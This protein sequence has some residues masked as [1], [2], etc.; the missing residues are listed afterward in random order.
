MKALRR[1]VVRPQLPQALAPLGPLVRNLRWSWHTPTKDLFADIDRS[2][3]QASGGD[4]VKLLG[5]ISIDR[6]DELA[7]DEDFLARMRALEADLETYLTA[8]RWYQRQL[9]DSRELPNLIAYFSMEYGI[10]ESLPNYSGGLGILAGDHL[11]SASDLGAPL[12]GVGLLYQFGYFWQSLSVDGWQQE[13]YQTHDPQGLPIDLVRRPDGSELRVTLPFPGNQSLSA[14]IWRAD[15][16]R[17]PLLLLD[18]VIDGNPEGLRAIT[19][20]LYG[21]NEDH[22]IKQEILLGVGG[23]RA[24][25]AFCDL[26]GRPQPEVFHMNEG[27]AG[28]LALERIRSL[29]EAQQMS[30]EAA[31]AVVR[32]ATVFTTHTPV[33][34]GID[35]FPVDLVRFYL[36]PDDD[37]ISRLAPGIPVGTVL[38]WGAE[39]DANRFNMAHM[40]LRLAQR[41]NGVARLHGEVSREM[42]AKLYPGFDADEVPIG[43]VTNGVHLPTW[44]SAEMFDIAEAMCQGELSSSDTWRH[45]DSVSTERLW[46]IRNTLRGRL[47]EMARASVR[48]SYLMRG[49]SEAELGW[50]ETI[51]DP[52]ILTFGFARRVSTYKR[53]T[54]MLSDPERLKKIL[55]DPHRPVQIIIAGKAHPADDGGKRLMQQMVTFTEDPEIRHRIVYLPDYDMGMASVLCAGADVWLNNPIRPL[56]ASG[57]SG[58]KAALNGVLNL[59][60]SDGWWDELYDGR[61][62][63][64]IPSAGVTDPDRR[65]TLESAALYELVESKV[66]P[67]FYQRADGDMPTGWVNMV[68][69]TLGYLGPR[70][71]ATRMVRDY[72][73]G[74]YAPAVASARALKA[75]SAAQ[76]FADWQQRIRARWPEVRVTAVDVSDLGTEPSLGATMRVQSTVDIDGLQPDDVRVELVVGLVDSDDNLSGMTVIPMR[77]GQGR[78]EAS[79]EFDRAGPVGYT[80]R[81]V[82]NHPLLASAAELGLVT[83]ASHLG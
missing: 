17:V 81:V 37:G 70:V 6:L 80:V 57:T 18:T 72:I 71:S 49:A 44:A 26:V 31:I 28:F 21:G 29:R 24:V 33:P 38:G 74:Y 19:D 52:N 65:D 14:R 75:N 58:M 76:S 41:A 32:S 27:H 20:R 73:N 48:Q 43:H 66:A 45:V 7:Q 61:D 34:A 67:L 68:R 39:D 40:G 47:V 55:L 13:H 69:H 5:S 35:R 10:T 3:W 42:F 25:R 62:G 50:T 1:F 9:A 79:A 15:V 78:F 8:D 2:L 77:P 83:E 53:L 12:I 46:D 59:S 30:T 23:V 63:W 60:I 56:E 82:P 16:G 22:R 36:D 51:L 4:P 11:K 54:L 64:R